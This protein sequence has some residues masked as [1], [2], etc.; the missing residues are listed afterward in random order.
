MLQTDASNTGLGA[1]L[2]QPNEQSQWHPIAYISRALT[3]LEKNYSTTEKELLAIVWAFTKFHPYLYGSSIIV[4]TDHQPL[5]SLIRKQHPPGRLLRW[6]L[7]LQPYRFTLSY[8]RGSENTIADSLSRV[9]VQVT[10]FLP[11]ESSIPVKHDQLLTAQ[12]ND[13]DLLMIIQQVKAQQPSMVMRY[14]LI[15]NL[16]YHISTSS[17]PRLCIPQALRSTYMSFYHAHPLSGHLGFHKV[18]TKLRSHYYW[19]KMRQDISK[20][21]RSCPICQEI[22]SPST[23]VAKLCPI[24][25]SQPFELVGWDIMGPFPLST[26]GNRYILVITEYLTRWCEAVPLPNTSASQVAHALLQRIIFPHGCPMTLLS[27]QGKQF[28]GEVM[29]ALSKQLGISQAFTSP[30]HPQTNGL[31]ERLNRTLKQMIAAYVDPLH[32]NWDTILPFV[33]HAYNTS[34]QS[35]TRVSPFR[36]LYGRDPKLPPEIH[37]DDEGPRHSEASDWWFYLRQHLP[38]IRRSLLHNLQVAQSRQK[39]LYDTGRK[40]V[41]YADGDLVML[42]YPVRKKGLNESLL[43]RWIGP[44]KIEARIRSNTYRLKRLQNG[45]TTTAHVIRIKPYSAHSVTSHPDS[46]FSTRGSVAISS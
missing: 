45:T 42:Y 27:D 10:Q 25:V 38:L 37:P 30:Y 2:L 13:P 5:L 15:N 28:R 32:Q 22:K 12:H 24:E 31:T 33:V 14:M 34:V 8:R 18:L 41:A 43:H 39:K 3:R 16:L 1:V 23:R 11:E 21:L 29:Q 20:H 36:A 7:T 40:E 6:T 4:E 35:S 46:T 19:P 9:E 26:S 17:S 44:Y